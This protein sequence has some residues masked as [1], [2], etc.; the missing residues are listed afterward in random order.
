MNILPE[1]LPIL[2]DDLSRQAVLTRVSTDG[3]I[4]GRLLRESDYDALVVTYLG[5]ISDALR[6]AEVLQSASTLKH[7]R[8]PGRED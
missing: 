6:Q 2:R 3:T 4:A 7:L 5:E 8:A 1:R